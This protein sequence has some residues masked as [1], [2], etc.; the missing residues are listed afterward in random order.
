M[1]KVK[2]VALTK[3][4]K[5]KKWDSFPRHAKIQLASW[6]HTAEFDPNSWDKK[7]EDLSELKQKR[8][9]QSVDKINPKIIAV[10]G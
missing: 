8:V 9:L 3:S 6:Y 10:I 4:Q 5:I 2:K 1:A 7:F